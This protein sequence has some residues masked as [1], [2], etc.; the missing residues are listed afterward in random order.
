MYDKTLVLDILHQL[1]EATEKIQQRF[2]QIE[3]VSDFTDSPFG[4]ERMDSICMQLIAIGE[5]LKNIDKI[6][7]RELLVQY[8]EIDWKGAKGLRDII[9]HQYFNV[10]A[11]E[12][13]WVCEKHLPPLSETIRQ[14][15]SDITL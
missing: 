15:I 7:K 13:F 8:P 10:D 11:E 5:S 1:L 2:E 6:T 3:T 4:M 14:M 12:I 9:A